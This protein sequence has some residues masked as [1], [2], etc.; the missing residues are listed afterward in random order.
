[1]KTTRKQLHVWLM[2]SWHMN[3]TPLNWLSYSEQLFLKIGHI[4]KHTLLLVFGG[5]CEIL[6]SFRERLEMV[7]QLLV[8]RRLFYGKVYDYCSW[9]SGKDA[10]KYTSV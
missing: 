9:T 3:F 4:N 10:F 6:V 7:S 2:D 8:P 1:M 5:K